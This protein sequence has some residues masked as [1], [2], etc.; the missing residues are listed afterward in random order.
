MTDH[1]PSILLVDD[2]EDICANMADIFTD[3]GYD[4]DVAH[5]GSDRPGAGARAALRR[6]AAGPE[7]AGHGRRDALPRDQEGAG[8]GRSAFLVTA[9]AGATRPMRPSPRGWQVLPKPVDFPR[10]LGLIDEAMGRPLVLVVDDDADLCANLWDLL[11][12]RGYRVCIAH[13]EARGDR[14]AA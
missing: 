12:E 7:D 10:L 6:G 5:E 9:Y 8:P 14:A 13:D 3:L 11:R 4:V 2:D 1:A